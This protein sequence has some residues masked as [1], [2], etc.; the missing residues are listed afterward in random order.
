MRFTF[1]RMFGA[2][3]IELWRANHLK[4]NFTADD[5]HAAYE[6]VMAG[7]MPGHE[8][9]D[10][11]DARFTHEAR[12]Q[13][14]GVGKI[15]LTGFKFVG[16]GRDAKGSAAFGVQERGKNGRRIEMGKAHE[17]DRAGKADQSRGRKVSNNAVVLNR[18]ILLHDYKL[19]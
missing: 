8:I 3:V 17:V 1:N 9:R 11:C 15:A 16:N 4:L 2:P 18:L 10:V 6:R 7:G 14:V 12:E 13:N 19:T 5:L